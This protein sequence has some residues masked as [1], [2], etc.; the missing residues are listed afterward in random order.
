TQKSK[1]HMDLIQQ[2]QVEQTPTECRKTS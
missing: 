1:K 2:Y